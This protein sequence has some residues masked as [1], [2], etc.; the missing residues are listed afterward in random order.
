MRKKSMMKGKVVVATCLEGPNFI[1]PILNLNK[2]SPLSLNISL[3]ASFFPS[4]E[5][6]QEK[7]FANRLPK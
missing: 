3:I 6:N 4:I 1:S 7:D 5:F 2:H